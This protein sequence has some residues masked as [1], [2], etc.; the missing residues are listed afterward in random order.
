MC[1]A[2]GKGSIL[3]A[4]HKLV[5]T[6]I[7]YMRVLRVYPQGLESRAWTEADV[8]GARR[9]WKTARQNTE[10]KTVCESKRNCR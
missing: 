7:D 4:A 6:Y 3:D 10:K 5:Q 8:L 2:C 9:V 1:N